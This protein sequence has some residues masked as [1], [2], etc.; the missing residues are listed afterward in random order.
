MYTFSV[1]TVP[2]LFEEV[3]PAFINMD[4]IRWPQIY[5]FQNR[6]SVLQN[7]SCSLAL[8]EFCRNK[9][10][11]LVNYMRQWLTV[12]VHSFHG[13]NV[14]ELEIILSYGKFEPP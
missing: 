13:D 11:R 2:S 8:Q 1:L 7:F 5:F 4:M 9:M 10:V 12:Q 3:V 14:V 6:T